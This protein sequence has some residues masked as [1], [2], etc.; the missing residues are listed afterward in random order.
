MPGVLTIAKKEFV[1]HVS[2]RTFLLCFGILLVIMVGGAFYQVWW[3]QNGGISTELAAWKYFPWMLQAELTGQLS[4]LGALVAIALSFNSINKERTE[5]SL[6][7]LLSYPIY[8]DKIILGKLVGGFL[9]VSLVTVASLTISFSIVLF[10]MSIPLTM[11]LFLRI[12]TVITMGT[13]LLVFFLCLGTAISTVVRDTSACLMILLLVTSLMRS[14]TLTM[15][16][17]IVSSLFPHSVAIPGGLNWLQY[18]ASWGSWRYTGGS[19]DVLRNYLWASPVE[20]YRNF[21]EAVFNLGS[22]QGHRG[23]Q[24]F[25]PISFQEQLIR[26]LDLVAVLILFTVATFIASYI[27]FTRRDI[28]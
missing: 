1:D 25:I 6:K 11:D 20:A 8:R 21:S 12:T 26:N 28:A 22:V 9:V 10:H 15:V 3:I 16:L 7:V 13:V 23:G 14:D 24:I 17:V 5:G 4:F 2:D 27:L 18:V 19:L